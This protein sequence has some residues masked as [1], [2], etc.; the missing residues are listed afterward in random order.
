MTLNSRSTA[1]SLPETYSARV[2]EPKTVVS[3]AVMPAVCRTFLE[4]RVVT[5]KD[6]TIPQ[7][8][9]PIAVLGTMMGRLVEIFFSA[10]IS[11]IQPDRPVSPM[12]ATNAL[13]S[14]TSLRGDTKWPDESDNLASSE[15]QVLQDPAQTR[16]SGQEHRDECLPERE[17][18]RKGNDRLAFECR[19]VNE[20]G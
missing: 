16:E 14:Q 12:A 10:V 11:K 15:P 18:E 8:N 13:H 1:K 7:S 17:G 2:R 6:R 5:K 3:N 19:E 20:Y 4:S 9:I